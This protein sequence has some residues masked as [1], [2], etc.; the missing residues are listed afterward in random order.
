MFQLLQNHEAAPWYM[1]EMLTEIKDLQQ[2]IPIIRISHT[3]REANQ[4]AD[5]LAKSGG[6]A[7]IRTR[8]LQEFGTTT[9]QIF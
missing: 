6:Q 9:T 8:Q 4:A 7:P 2:Q 1:L 3:S 5:K